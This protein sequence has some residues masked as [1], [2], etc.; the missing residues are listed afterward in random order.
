MV[1][2]PATTGQDRRATGAHLVWM[3]RQWRDLEAVERRRMGGR[4]AEPEAAQAPHRAEDARKQDKALFGMGTDGDGLQVRSQAQEV[5]HDWLISLPEAGK[6]QAAEVGKGER[7]IE[8]EDIGLQIRVEHQEQ[9]LERLQVK[10]ARESDGRR[11]P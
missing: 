1:G 8:T 5:Q 11:E 7:Q 4:P 6:A 3:P 10:N 9:L 2:G